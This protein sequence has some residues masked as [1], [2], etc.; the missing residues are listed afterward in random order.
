MG[1]IDDI[2][3][4][5]GWIW[6]Q[7]GA[8]AANAAWDQMINGMVSWVTD[9]IAWF[10]AALLRFFEHAS[11]PNLAASWFSGSGSQ[12][13][14]GVVAGLALSLLLLFMLIAVVQG[15]LSGDGV[16]MAARL[17][18]DVPLAILGIAATIGVTQVLLGATDELSHAV[19]DGTGAGT[20]A[21]TVLQ[22]LGSAG[23]FS[24]QAT[25]VVFL[26]GLVAVVAAFLLWVELL[27]RASLLYV[28]LACSPLAFAC[29]V[30]PAA[31]RV[32]H[33]LAELVLALV[34][35][36]V[37][38]AIALAVAA[39]ALTQGT[40]NPAVVPTGEAQVG[41]LLVGVIMFLLAALAPFIV[42]KL[43][44]VVEAAV[45]A[46][47]ISR[48]PARTTQSAAIT[49]S[50]VARLAGTG[51]GAL[52]GASLATSTTTTTRPELGTASA[53]TGT[54]S[55][56]PGNDAE[57][58]KRSESGRARR[59]HDLA[60]APDTPTTPASSPSTSPTDLAGRGADPAPPQ[61]DTR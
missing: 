30:W 10:V 9:A 42:L 46:Q 12:S 51:T 23:A 6:S 11:T 40:N 29:F 13:P 60:D 54:K 5:L 17:A 14:Y 52:A 34:L 4:G 49:G 45:V 18:R 28:L 47:G 38:I 35:S 19:L 41:T 8:R 21:K 39:G 57:D 36:K 48:A 44:P 27:I 22:H 61:N 3:G 25:F 59:A 1:I 7:T 58:P 33:R 56:S 53:A 31:R 43:F 24:G 20:Q 55:A 50:W 15:V 32:L 26:L 37:V 2:L 16:A